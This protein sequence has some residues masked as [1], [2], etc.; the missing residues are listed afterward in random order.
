MEI[1]TWMLDGELE[2]K[3][4]EG[5]RGIIYPGLAQRMSAGTGIWHSEMNPRHD[6]DVHFVQ[7]WVPPDTERIRPGYE[8]LDIN[9]QLAGGGLVPIASG[10]GHAA[11]ISI[12]QR[13]AVLWGGRLKPTETVRLPD[14]P[15]VHVF[16][17]RGGAT[18]EG[19]GAL[20]TGDAVRLTRA[21]ARG[22]TADAST[23]AEVLVWESA[24]EPAGI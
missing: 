3:D 8:Q 12:R 5:H 23:G 6:K 2:H 4:S 20:A 14:A 22:L 13:D 9:A 10:R 1:V 15:F 7:M 19:A 18:L 21:G 16:V 17:A 24:G 11:A